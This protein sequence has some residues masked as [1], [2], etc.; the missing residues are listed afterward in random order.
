MPTIAVDV[1]PLQAVHMDEARLF[2]DRYD[3]MR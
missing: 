1:K 3:L 2:A